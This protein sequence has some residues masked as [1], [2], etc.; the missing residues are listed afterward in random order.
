MVSQ[1]PH[2]EVVESTLVLVVGKQIPVLG[3]FSFGNMADLKAT[4]SRFSM[5]NLP[6]TALAGGL[7]SGLFDGDQSNNNFP[8]KAEVVAGSSLEVMILHL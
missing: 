7:P 3:G 5:E 1:P 4:T 2:P 6:I 8:V